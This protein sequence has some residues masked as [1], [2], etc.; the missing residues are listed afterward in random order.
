MVLRSKDGSRAKRHAPRVLP[1][2]PPRHQL[3][4]RSAT[5]HSLH[6]RS[7][8]APHKAV[9]SPKY[10]LPFQD[11]KQYLVCQLTAKL[12]CM[13]EYNCVITGGDCAE[14]E[15]GEARAAY[16]GVTRLEKERKWAARVWVDLQAED[17][18]PL[19][20]RHRRRAGVVPALPSALPSILRVA[21]LSSSDAFS[22]LTSF[23]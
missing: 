22:N 14:A 21:I 23:A 16:R 13:S 8:I 5:T 10:H 17:R 11:C 6:P 2:A 20:L 3:R 18:R 9:V 12:P 19:R 15:R 1:G 4:H 7:T